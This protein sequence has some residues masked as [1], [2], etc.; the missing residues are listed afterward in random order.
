MNSCFGDNLIFFSIFWRMYFLE[1][2]FYYFIIHLDCF[3]FMFCYLSFLSSCKGEKRRNSSSLSKLGIWFL[4]WLTET[5]QSIFLLKLKLCTDSS[6]SLQPH[7][8]KRLWT[9][10]SNPACE[11]M[12]WKEGQSRK[13]TAVL[14]NCGLTILK[15]F[16]FCK[17]W[18]WEHIQPEALPNPWKGLV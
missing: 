8:K 6:T 18:P 12:W 1:D 4:S 2:N 5:F 15:F 14:T 17:I 3:N 9:L 10:Q 16:K 7:P 13:E 11:E